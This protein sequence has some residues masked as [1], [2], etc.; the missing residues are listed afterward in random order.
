MNRRQAL[1]TLSSGLVLPG[2]WRGAGAEQV[3]AQAE[4]LDSLATARTDG[5]Q[6]DS[7][8]AWV[9]KKAELS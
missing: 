7:R 5:S 8:V 9:I 3:T 6:T 2:L 4:I 1:V